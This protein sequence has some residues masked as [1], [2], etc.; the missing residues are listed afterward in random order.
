MAATM[1]DLL[2]AIAARSREQRLPAAISGVVRLDVDDAGRTD[3]W[4]LTLAKGTVTVARRGGE[5][6]AV[7]RGDAATFVA[8]LSGEANMMAAILRGAL[9]VEGRMLLLVVL[10]R[11]SPGEEQGADVPAAGYARRQS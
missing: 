4:Y 10:Q 5:P 9:E 7:V 6:D 1:K 3:H 8:V 11:F 2:E